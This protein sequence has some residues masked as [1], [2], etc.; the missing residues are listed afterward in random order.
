MTQQTRQSVNEWFDLTGA[1]AALLA[2]AGKT[3]WKSID[4]ILDNFYEGLM[5]REDTRSFFPSREVAAHAKAAQK[6]HWGRLLSGRFDQDY[7]DSAARVGR[8]HYKIQLP[9]ELYMGGYARA[10]S[11]MIACVTKGG[12]F[13]GKAASARAQVL[14]RALL[15]DCD[16]VI[17]AYFQ[18]ESEDQTQALELLSG[19]IGRLEQGDLSG[20]ISAGAFP[21]KFEAL[22]TSYNTLLNRWSGQIAQAAGHARA[23]DGQLANTARMAS[24]LAERSQSQAATLEEAVASVSQIAAS[25]KEAA[26]RLDAASNRSALNRKA[27]EKGKS[28]VEQ[29]IEAMQRIEDS[30]EKISRIIEVIE[31]I[32]FQTNL[33]A[34]NAGVEA[35]RAGEAGR[36]FAVVASEVRAL[37][38]RTSDSATE[39]KSL[40]AESSAQ[41][42]DGGELVRESGKSLEEIRNG[43]SQV[44]GLMAEA[45][46]MISEQSVSLGEID[47]S[48]AE[49][50]RTTQDTAQLAG[51]VYETTSKLA[52]DSTA[53][54]RSME[55]FRTGSGA[56]S[57]AALDQAFHRA[58]R[59]G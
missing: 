5:A 25:A 32:S 16:E 10:G 7:L 28:V 46:A 9:F 27:A 57:E 42:Q 55:S 44:S 33:L 36:G 58:A 14:M 26:D 1:S 12:L 23:V 17:R 6:A 43:A 40:I 49:L 4:G 29:A 54:K 21:S 48:V 22:R 38:G 30:S 8:A 11:E 35:A 41:V 51:D 18:A 19:A 37:A 24:D 50:G 34:L 52:Q 20:Q 39:I 2:D 13:S 45:S 15:A 47:T 3:V 56:A 31:D 53:L 59:T